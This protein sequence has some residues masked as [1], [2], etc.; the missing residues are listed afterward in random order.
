MKIECS[1]PFVIPSSREAVFV[2]SPI[3]VYS[4]RRSEPTLPDITAPLLSPI[5]IWKPS[6]WPELVQPLAERGSRTSSISRA[7]ASARSAWSGCS[8]GAPKTAM[9]PSPM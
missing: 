4:S 1:V 2:V 9:I 7:A 5:P 8:S 6:P 3:V